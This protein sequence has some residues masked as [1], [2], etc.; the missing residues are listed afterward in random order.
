VGSS[1]L[2]SD[3]QSTLML[4][5][6]LSLP[7][8]GVAIVVGFF[9]GLFQAVTQIQDQS[10]PQVVKIVA[11]LGA[12]ALTGRLINGTLVEHTGQLLDQLPIVGRS[13]VR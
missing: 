5:F 10:L 1:E 9:V 13:V 4:V 8:L 2:I 12:I 6:V 7:A 3:A 11:V